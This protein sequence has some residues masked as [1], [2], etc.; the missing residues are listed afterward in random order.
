MPPQRLAAL[1]IYNLKAPEQESQHGSRQTQDFLVEKG[2]L[3][4]VA[5]GG[6]PQGF[7]LFQV[8]HLSPIIMAVCVLGFYQRS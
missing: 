5:G 8:L 7:Q 1:K 3:G 4:G 6:V 2:I